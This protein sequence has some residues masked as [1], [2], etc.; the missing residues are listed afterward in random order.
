MPKLRTIIVGASTGFAVAFFTFFLFGAFEHG[1]LAFRVFWGIH[2]PETAL[3]ERL[4]E[5]YY[6]NNTDQGL[7]FLVPVHFGYWI[8]LG[9][10]AAWL[11]CVIQVR[12]ARTIKP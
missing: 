12:H 7:I 4:T 8:V 6:P 2:W 1:S 11:Y 9:V 5:T 3:V 10:A